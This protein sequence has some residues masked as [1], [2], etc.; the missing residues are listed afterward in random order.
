MIQPGRRPPQSTRCT[1]A[2][3][4]QSLL[5]RDRLAQLGVQVLGLA[6]DERA[7]LRPPPTVVAHDELDLV[8]GE[9]RV[10]VASAAGRLHSNG[11]LRQF[12]LLLSLQQFFRFSPTHAVRN[13]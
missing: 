10:R 2:P 9:A 1:G 5:T 4:R 7:R 3:A 8:R 11:E 13:P 6:V 12:A